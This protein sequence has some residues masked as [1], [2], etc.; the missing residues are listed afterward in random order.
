MDLQAAYGNANCSAR[1]PGHAVCN[2]RNECQCEPG[3]L[4]PRCATQD[5]AFSA[6][7]TGAT[8]AVGVSV[9][10]VVLG[11]VLGAAGVL[12][13]R[14]NRPTIPSS[15]RKQQGGSTPVI[16]PPQAQ[17]ERPKR[18]PPPTPP[19]AGNRPKP[20]NQ[21][22]TAARQALRPVPPPKV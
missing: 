12:W 17:V 9:L 14:R 1:C 5:Q 13:R 2:H 10:L 21:N 20:Q 11:L 15:Q 22:Y 18:A 7:S 8:V 19:P 3:W 16:S 4:P 6:L